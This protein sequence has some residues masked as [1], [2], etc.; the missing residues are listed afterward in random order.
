MNRP[1]RILVLGIVAAIAGFLVLTALDA[2]IYHAISPTLASRERLDSTWWYL[3][4]RHTGSFWTWVLIAG[5]VLGMDLVR[6]R[7]PVPPKRAVFSRG[8]FLVLSA[9]ASG[10]VAELLKLIIARER[11]ATMQTLDN[12]T[13]MLVY[14]GHHFRGLFAGFLDGSNLG[15]PSSHA[16]T[17]AGGALA[18]TLLFPRLGL[19]AVPLALGC[20]ISR[21]LTGA[22]FASDVFA[23]FVLAGFLVLPLRRML[24]LTICEPPL[25]H[26]TRDP[27][28]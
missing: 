16:A 2:R 14:Q 18:L 27:D 17:A 1:I 20:G 25:H 10:L 5:T 15:L 21:L 3:I 6:A 9:A 24:G 13:E 26:A 11:P 22:H 8:L 23:G 19:V 28:A 7:T 12:G 4:L